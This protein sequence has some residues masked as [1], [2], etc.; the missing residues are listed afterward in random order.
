MHTS[1]FD[2]AE[3]LCNTETASCHSESLESTCCS[4]KQ[5][6]S[7]CC[8]NTSEFIKGISLEQQAQ[9]IQKVRVFS[10]L[11]FSEFFT[12]YFGSYQTSFFKHKLIK[13]APRLLDLGILFQVFR[14]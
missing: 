2:E 1:F 3:S 14:I 5:K 6:D 11:L 12:S 7:N 13:Q 10:I 9:A 8:L 4:A